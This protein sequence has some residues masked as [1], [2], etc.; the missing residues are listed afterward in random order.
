M[1]SLDIEGAFDN[2][3]WPA[4]KKQLINKRCPKNL[5]GLITSYLCDRTVRVNY[6][7]AVFE[8]G[9]NKGCIQ[10]SI[11][12]PTFWNLILDTLLQKLNSLGVYC[13][14]FADDVVLIFSAPTVEKIQSTANTTLEAVQTWGKQNKLNF[15][16]HKTNAM[17]ITRKLKFDLPIIN[18]SGIQL[19]LVK[20]IKLLGLIIDCKLTFNSHVAA[21]CRKAA[22][23]Y[24]QLACAAKVS[25]G[26]NKEIIRTIY[27]SVIE[28]IVLYAASAW[29]P[30]AE[31]L[32]IRD[33][34]SSLQR[35]FAIKI[36]KAYRTV[37][38]TSALILSGLLPLDLRVQEAAAFFK[39]KKGYSEEHIPPGREV[40]Q[41]VGYL[42]NPHPSTLIITEFERLENLDPNTLETYHVV[43]PQI[44]TDGSKIE[45]KVGA[46]LTWWDKG[47]ETRYSTF[48][49]ESHNTVFQS[50]MYAL[51]RAVKMARSSKAKTVNIM[52]DSR[53][54]LELLKNPCVTHQ[55][56][57]EIKKLIAETRAEDREFQMNKT[58]GGCYKP[59]TT[60]SESKIL[61]IIQDQVEPLCN[62]F[63]SGA[64]YFKDATH[65]SEPTGSKSPEI[66]NFIIVNEVEKSDSSNLLDTEITRYQDS[67]MV[68][69]TQEADIS[70]L[71]KDQPKKK[72][73][74]DY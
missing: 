17:I 29:Y 15:A 63:D 16:A 68:T 60:D 67:S 32:S 53:S 25:W 51:Y 73:V 41:K 24:K 7:R 9:T 43:G 22:D 11:G 26:L 30:A 13:Q 36:C 70:E 3:W 8:R 21:T 14:A 39:I 33:Q 12:G 50:E 64:L 42:H 65:L 58:G 40:E 2:A 5:Y 4:L 18:M 1:V 6:A 74:K 35:G 69:L 48:R 49:L 44:F 56:A 62:P 55:L 59:K 66:E 31:K 19:K 28:P 23:I 46:A 10:G 52:S 27:V 37:S 57:L 38:L 20:E 71:P 54:S 34:L 61:A 72:N 47:K 45:G